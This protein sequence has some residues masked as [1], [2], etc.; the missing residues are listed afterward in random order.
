MKISCLICLEVFTEECQLSSTFCGHLF[1]SNC[2]E[3]S[4]ESNNTCPNC[5]KS[6]APIS[7]QESVQSVHQIYL[8]LISSEISENDVW[9]KREKK[10]LQSA[11][12]QGSLEWYKLI[13]ENAKNKNPADQLGRTPIHY[14]A[15][16]GRISICKFILENVAE[17]NPKDYK[18]RTPL[19]FAADVGRLDLCILFYKHMTGNQCY[20]LRTESGKAES[21]LYLQSLLF[22]S[23]SS[24]LFS[25]QPFPEYN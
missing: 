8:P 5:R 21:A 14:A 22:S 13:T 11:A 23:C 25:G 18:G 20:A 4:L 12:E 24:T 16:N 2:L 19:D 7:V 3:K 17:K 10:L 15:Q 9:T 6:C 1:H